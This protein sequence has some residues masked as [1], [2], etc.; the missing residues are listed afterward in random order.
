LRKSQYFSF[1][2][3]VLNKGTTWYHFHNVFGM[4]RPLTGVRTRDS[5]PALY[6]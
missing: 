3:S 5:M 2:C 4:T 1:K 6:H